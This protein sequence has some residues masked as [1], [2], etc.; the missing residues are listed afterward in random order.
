[1][2]K[3]G[4]VRVIYTDNGKKRS[5]TGDAADEGHYLQIDLKGSKRRK[6]FNTILLPWHV[7][8]KVIVLKP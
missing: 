3:I 8:S 7:I 5:A 4:F 1:M 6:K 2:R